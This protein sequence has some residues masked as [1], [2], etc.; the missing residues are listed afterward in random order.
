MQLELQLPY[1]LLINAV[2]AIKK[3][4]GGHKQI[5]A[6]SDVIQR[7]LRSPTVHFP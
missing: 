6:M 1:T 7:L 4:L 2:Q 5:P 3:G